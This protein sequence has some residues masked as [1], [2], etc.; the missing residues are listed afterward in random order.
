MKIKIGKNH[1]LSKNGIHPQ[2]VDFAD[3]PPIWVKEIVLKEK[4]LW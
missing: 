3:P 1:F 4:L 2:V